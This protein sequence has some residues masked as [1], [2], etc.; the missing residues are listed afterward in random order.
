MFTSLIPLKLSASVHLWPVYGKKIRMC[1]RAL[2]S[3]FG[4]LLARP[5]GG[6]GGEQVQHQVGQLALHQLKPLFQ[7]LHIDIFQLLAVVLCH[8][9]ES[10]EKFREEILAELQ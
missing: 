6:A 2:L 9:L 10:G 5:G 7:W 3:S 1:W 4:L 8:A